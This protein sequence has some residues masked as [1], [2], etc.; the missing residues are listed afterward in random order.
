MVQHDEGLSNYPNPFSYQTTIKYQISEPSQVALAVFDING[1][2]VVQL[3]D[4]KQ[5][6]GVYEVPFVAGGL[7]RRL[8]WYTLRTGATQM[9]KK[10]AIE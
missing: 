9:T 5:E 8:Y 7:P 2:L 10:M 1:R 6:A 4:E 3:V